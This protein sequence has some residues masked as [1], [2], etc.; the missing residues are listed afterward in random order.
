M[1]ELALFAG[2]GGGILGGKL[3]G[4][5]TVCYVERD[6]YCIEALKARIKDGAISDA[7]IWDDVKTFDGRPWAG[8][9]D[10]I[11]AGFPC[12]PFS[13]S[14]KMRAGLDN[15]N[16]WP[17]TV[18]II[19]EV[20]PQWCLLENVPGLLSGSH[21]YFSQILRSLAEL[22]FAA[23]WACIPA[24][25][26]GAHHHRNRLWIVAYAASRNEHQALEA[27]AGAS[28]E[29]SESAFGISAGGDGICLGLPRN[30]AWYAR[31][32]GVARVADGVARRVERIRAIGNGQ[33]PAVVRAAW[34]ALTAPLGAFEE[35]VHIHFNLRK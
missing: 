8:A 3:L 34:I 23:R 15:R 19:A 27:G 21:G 31:K 6:K 20:R 9:V 11:S 22:G 17:E 25:A 2:A 13:V 1:N 35:T 18:R 32:P 10:I 29:R 7:P 4:W 30:T 33:V 16:M 5:K 24:A 26:V 14:G 28:Q 12:Q